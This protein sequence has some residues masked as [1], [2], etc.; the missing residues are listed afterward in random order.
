VFGVV[1]A[2]PEVVALLPVHVAVMSMAGIGAGI[3]R[4]LTGSLWLL[5][6]V[7]AGA[8]IALYVG[9]ACRAAA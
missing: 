3:L 6:G 9:L 5:V 2:G 7:H 8:D 1:H 4:R